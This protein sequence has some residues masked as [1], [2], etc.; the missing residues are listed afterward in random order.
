MDIGRWALATRATTTAPCGPGQRR[1][2]AS[3]TPHSL[4][5]ANRGAR[6][7]LRSRIACDALP[8]ALLLRCPCCVRCRCPLKRCFPHYGQSHPALAADAPGFWQVASWTATGG[9]E[10]RQVA[11]L[12][13]PSRQSLLGWMCAS[14]F[15]YVTRPAGGSLCGIPPRTRVFGAV[16]PHS[17]AVR[18]NRP[19]VSC[20]CPLPGTSETLCAVL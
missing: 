6:E 8:A 18:T 16:P 17:V 4:D 20:L 3:G 11:A 12:G 2:V 13:V 15:Y 19:D 5:L 10:P 7:P 9:I 1:C 14:A